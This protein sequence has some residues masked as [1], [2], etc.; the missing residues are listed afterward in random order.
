[1][2]WS[3][4]RRHGTTTTSPSKPHTR[5]HHHDRCIPPITFDRATGG[6]PP[7]ST[8][9]LFVKLPVELYHSVT[10][11]LTEPDLESLALVDIDCSQLART[12]QFADVT[13]DFSLEAMGVLEKLAEELWEG[14]NENENEVKDEDEDMSSSEENQLRTLRRG[15]RKTRLNPCIRHLKITEGTFEIL[16]HEIEKY[17]TMFPLLFG[18]HSIRSY[19]DIQRAYYTS[20][21]MILERGL[22]NLSSLEWE[23][24]GT[25]AMMDL[26][27]GC[28]GMIAGRPSTSAS[29]VRQLSLNLGY[30]TPRICLTSMDVNLETG[31]GCWGWALETLVLDVGSADNPVIPESES[32]EHGGCGGCGCFAV[33]LLRCV[34][35]NL[36]S[37]V[38]KDAGSHH[39]SFGYGGRT[40]SFPKLQ[41]VALDGIRM[42]DFTVLDALLGENTR[43]NCLKVDVE[44]MTA[45]NFLNER[46]HITSLESFHWTTSRR[47][48][49]PSA[50]DDSIASLLPFISAN[51]QLRSISGSSPMSP[52]FIEEHLLPLVV[53]PASLSSSSIPFFDQLTSLHIVWNSTSIPES[54]LRVIGSLRSLNRLW[55]SAGTQFGWR[56]DWKVDHELLAETLKPL[57]NL[58]TLVVTRDSYEVRGHPLL[59]CSIER[60]YA[61]RVLPKEEVFAEYLSQDEIA[62]LEKFFGMT[63]D[64]SMPFEQARALHSKLLK[65][66][67]ERWHQCKMVDV[68]KKCYVVGIPSLEKCFVGQYWFAIERRERMVEGGFASADEGAIM[69]L[70]I[71][72]ARCGVEG[73]NR[74]WGL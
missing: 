25:R 47:S 45:R 63:R 65:T 62:L 52:S 69:I 57:I 51:D 40:I 23:T 28:L 18:R 21:S 32:S 31:T 60:Y 9:P 64:G 33:D 55:L 16:P 48:R 38:W 56:T 70:P 22:P 43:V 35:K 19:E 15:A 50:A 13:L 46:G 71:H 14:E 58:K 68:V 5:A 53:H 61:N 8:F 1:M 12:V 26:T 30:F 3:L 74:W 72:A 4:E 17:Q 7:C 59:D 44:S 36:K 20:L 41:S 66:A 6:R 67:W 27:L 73:V 10:S 54:A 11:H 42:R 49:E 37:L 29:P 24:R 2:T 39:H 34:S